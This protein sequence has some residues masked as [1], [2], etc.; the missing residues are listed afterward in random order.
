AEPFEQL[1]LPRLDPLCRRDNPL[2]VFLQRGCHVPLTPAERLP[3]L[4]VRGNEMP[5]RVADL[6]EVPEH[7]VVADLERRDTRSRPLFGL[8]AGH[9]IPPPVAQSAALIEFR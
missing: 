7:S 3:A 5:V 9:R 6:D 8:D 4:V 2:L 1:T